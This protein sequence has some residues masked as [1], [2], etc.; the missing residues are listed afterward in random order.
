MRRRERVKTA[1]G[2]VPFDAAGYLRPDD[3][4]GFLS[5]ALPEGSPRVLPPLARRTAADA[6][7]PLPHFRPSEAVPKHP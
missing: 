4:A 2:A 6:W 7:A 3:L 5:E 1:K